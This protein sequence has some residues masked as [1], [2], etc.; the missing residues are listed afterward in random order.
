[1][2][3]NDYFDKVVVINLDRRPDRLEKIDAQLKKLDISY[4]RFSAYD[5]VKLNIEPLMGCTKSHLDVWKQSFGKRV[6]ILEDDAEF[7]D[8]F[9]ERFD[10]VMA[11]LP[12]D[13]AVM[14]LGILVQRY[15]STTHD[16]GYKNWFNI[17]QTAGTHAYSLHPDK[18]R[19]FYESLK[20]YQ[21]H[22]DIGIQEKSDSMLTLAA[23]PILVKQGTSFSDLRLREVNDY[24]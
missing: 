22:I 14:Y 9:Q 16:V 23:L 1:M 13:Y 5:A 8:D 24:V 11:E 7:C 19:Y 4:E 15:I 12:E 2:R 21:S 10:E 17:K 6:L 20:D 3:V 18:V